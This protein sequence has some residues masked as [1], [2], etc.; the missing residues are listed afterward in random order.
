[1]CIRDR[2]NNDKEETVVLSKTNS[3]TLSDNV[4]KKIENYIIDNNISNLDKDNDKLLITLIPADTSNKYYPTSN[5]WYY[6]KDKKVYAYIELN[7]AGNYYRY[8]YKGSIDD[9]KEGAC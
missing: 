5:S 4:Y 9:I 6:I 1:M 3:R 2:D 8:C 7:E